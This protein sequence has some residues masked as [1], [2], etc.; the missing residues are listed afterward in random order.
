MSP[1]IASSIGSIYTHRKKW[2]SILSKLEPN[3]TI[4]NNAPNRFGKTVTT[5]KY[6]SKLPGK[7]LYLSDR[8]AQIEEL[9]IA[10]SLHWQGHKIK[11]ERKDDPFINSLMLQ[12]L[13]ANIICRN[14]CDKSSCGYKTQFTIPQDVIVVAPKEY[15]QTTYTQENP[16]DSII[17]DENLEKAK[18]ITYHYPT[19][20]KDI[21]KTNLVD[22]TFYEIIGKI[23]KGSTYKKSDLEYIEQKALLAYNKLPN[24]IEMS[25]GPGYS[26]LTSEEENLIAYLN[27]IPNTFEWISYTMKYG[28]MDHYYK[29]YLHFAHELQSKN[30]STLII[31][32][33]S[34]D[35]V[36][37]DQ[38]LERYPK[39]LFEPLT[40]NVPLINKESYLLHYNHHNKSLSKNTITDSTG[41]KF[42]GHYGKEIYEMV[43]NTV[44]FAKKRKLKTG[45]ITFK[46]L[47]DEIKELFDDDVHV[48]SYFGGHQGS[49]KFDDVDILIIIGTFHLNQLGLYQKHYIINNEFLKD[50]H[51]IW[52]G[53]NNQI[54]N[55]MQINLSNNDKLNNVKI[56]KLN[57]EHQQAIFRSGAHIQPGKIVVSFGFVPEGIEKIL[58]YK[59]FISKHQLLGLLSKIK[60]KKKT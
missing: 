14:F 36:I 26:P 55:G 4:I 60:T 2:E 50:D 48:T 35:R 51:A 17:L 31:L 56:Y 9:K 53:E 6:Y 42:G 27:N 1:S 20:S 19:I 18:K 52:G 43:K 37:Y 25:I 10:K 15:L 28:I 33:T 21:F 49:N 13:G 59:K 57:E 8:H 22:D 39:P 45:I 11:C 29:P 34:F 16:W 5:L 58:T 24:V 54:I 12:G 3:Q 40:Y 46:S 32:N 38:L 30:K 47:T 44:S 23:L 41:K 7:F